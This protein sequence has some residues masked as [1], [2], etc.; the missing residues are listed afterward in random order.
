MKV[1]VVQGLQDVSAVPQNARIFKA[2]FPDRVQLV[3]IDHA[4]HAL[5]PEQPRQVAAAVLKFLH[6][7]A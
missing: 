7:N 2:D 5:L 6:H 4:A 1:L 3:E